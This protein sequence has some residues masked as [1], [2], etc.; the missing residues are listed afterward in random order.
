LKVDLR[1]TEV[2]RNG[3]PVL[4]LAKEFELLRYFIEHPG[5]TLSREQ[6]LKEV[7]GYGVTPSTRTVDVH[8]LWLRQKI[9]EDPRQP[10]LILTVRGLGYKFAG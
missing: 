10:R 6:L 2:F 7:W 9:E 5:E 8:V 4:L 1:G 3:R